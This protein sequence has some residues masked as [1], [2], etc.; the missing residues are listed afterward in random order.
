MSA[1]TQCQQA[2]RHIARA[3]QSWELGARYRDG[4]K[5]LERA[6]TV[7]RKVTEARPMRKAKR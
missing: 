2:C 7:L 1:R 6:L 4:G 5:H 3:R